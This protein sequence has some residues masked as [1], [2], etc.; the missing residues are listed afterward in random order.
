LST[1]NGFQTR[2]R[3]FELLVMNLIFVASVGGSLNSRFNNNDTT[4]ILGG[5]RRFPE[6]S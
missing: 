1:H 4:S 6:S 2:R 3:R 5:G